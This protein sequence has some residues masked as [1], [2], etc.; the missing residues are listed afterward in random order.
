MSENELG[1][2]LDQCLADTAL[3]ILAGG[4][5][6]VVTALALFKGKRSWP[7]WLGTGVGIGMG[8]N[9]CQNQLKR[10]TDK[11]MGQNSAKNGQMR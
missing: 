10:D 7:V 3:K 8:F 9:N 11:T 6:G 2:T 5:I 4:S 1:R